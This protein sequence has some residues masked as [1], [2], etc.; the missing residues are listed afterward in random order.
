M[1]T[2]RPRHAVA[3][4]A[5]LL[6]LT[7]HFGMT[8]LYLTPATPLKQALGGLPDRYMSPYFE[9]RWELFAPQPVKNSRYLLVA[10]R[11]VDEPPVGEPV[12]HDLTRPLLDSKYALRITPADRLH[13]AVQWLC[14]SDQWSPPRQH[15]QDWYGEALRLC[16]RIAT[17]DAPRERA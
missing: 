7:V 10:C 13:R 6:V 8:L 12:W 5:V 15:K 16:E 14:W 2:I 17:S 11:A 1:S 4:A 3:L 9:Q